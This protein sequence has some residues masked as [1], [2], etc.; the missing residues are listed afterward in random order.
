[1]PEPRSESGLWDAVCALPALPIGRS[2]PILIQLERLHEQ[3]RPD[4]IM[5][6]SIYKT[7]HGVLA[8]TVVP[9]T[10]SFRLRYAPD[11]DP[12]ATVLLALLGAA[13]EPAD[14][15]RRAS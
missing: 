8:L 15:L 1:M 4:G 5:S 2:L 14:A 13:R 12:V 10:S 3:L 6:F 7:T 9:E 11:A